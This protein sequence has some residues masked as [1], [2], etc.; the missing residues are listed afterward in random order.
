MTIVFNKY[1]GAGNNFLIIDNRKGIFNPDDTKLVN[2]LC[3][4]RFRI[5]TEC[6]NLTTNYTEIKDEE[7]GFA[8]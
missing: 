2:K 5:R 6:E 4:R 1:R 3:N 7:H 8:L